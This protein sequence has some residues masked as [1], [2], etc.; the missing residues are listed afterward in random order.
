MILC[1]IL[2]RIKPNGLGYEY[3]RLSHIYGWVNTTLAPNFNLDKQRLL[4]E[5][6]QLKN[7]KI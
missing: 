7:G 6:E 2:F 3:L 4:I 1:L 5:L